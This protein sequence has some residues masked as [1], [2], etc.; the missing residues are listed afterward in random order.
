MATGQFGE[1][2]SI[3]SDSQDGV[4]GLV[5]PLHKQA[6]EPAGGAEDYDAGVVFF[7]HGFRYNLLHTES[8]SNLPPSQ[9]RFGEWRFFSGRN[10][11][12]A[13]AVHD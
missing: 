7:G 8:N 10:G 11:Y 12:A 1:S 6:S 13:I 3:S 2:G 5:K 4:P 9:S